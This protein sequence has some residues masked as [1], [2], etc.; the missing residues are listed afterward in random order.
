MLRLRHRPG[1]K[2]PD[3][4]KSHYSSEAVPVKREG[5]GEALL[6]QRVRHFPDNAR[7]GGVRFFAQP[8]AS[9]G[10]LNAQA[11]HFRREL[12][13]QVEEER[14]CPSGMREAKQFHGVGIRTNGTD[15]DA[16]PVP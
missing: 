11:R 15:E 7:N 2:L 3:D 14:R 4:L 1:P 10:K 12:L 16:A 9:S 13:C 6:S 5:A 8:R